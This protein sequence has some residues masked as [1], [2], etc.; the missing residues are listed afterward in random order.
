MIKL[1]LTVVGVNLVKRGDTVYKIESGFKCVNN[2][3]KAIKDVRY[4]MLLLPLELLVRWVFPVGFG[5]V[6]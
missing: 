1:T 4:G 5:H 6:Y 3:L 2:M